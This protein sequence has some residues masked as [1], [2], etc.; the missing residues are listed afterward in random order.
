MQ[1]CN[2]F[3]Y[4]FVSTYTFLIC[5]LISLKVLMFVCPT[6]SELR[7]YGCCHLCYFEIFEE[8]KE[9][10][11]QSLSKLIFILVYG[12][13][14]HFGISISK[15]RWRNPICPTF[16]SCDVIKRG[17]WE[18]NWERNPL[19][20]RWIIP[21]IFMTSQESKVGQIGLRR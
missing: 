2:E 9:R 16:D 8:Q 19:K 4:N 5:L 7:F 20:K 3:T 14:V 21:L 6:V 18:E 13:L 11:D 1:F 17:R 15:V 10:H 12:N